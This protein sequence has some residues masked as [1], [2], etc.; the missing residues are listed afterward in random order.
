MFIEA[1]DHIVYSENDEVWS[2]PA[3][4]ETEAGI[5]FGFLVVEHFDNEWIVCKPNMHCVA[6]ENEDAAFE[7]A[8]WQV[9]NVW[10][11]ISE[12]EKNKLMAACIPD[13]DEADEYELID[14]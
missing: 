1:A 10:T 5:E 9:A 12:E 6:C 4:R 11:I 2:V 8:E 14:D 13:D 3:K 7:E